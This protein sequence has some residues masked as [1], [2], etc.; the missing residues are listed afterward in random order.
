MPLVDLPHPSHHRS[1]IE[2]DLDAIRENVRRFRE[3]AGEEGGVMPAVKADA[4]GHGAVAVTREALAAGAA[5]VAVA[6][7][8]EGEELRAAG[9]DAPVL[10]LGASLPEEV[11]RAVG[12]GLGLGI[13]DLEIARL[14]SLE[15]M[16][17]GRRAVLHLKVDTG[18]GRLGILPE[19]AVR[20]AREIAGLP[21][22]V[23][24]G[25]YMHF[26]DATDEAYS[27]EQ[28]RRF[29]SATEA[30][31][32]SGVRPPLLHAANSAGAILYGDAR[33]DLIRPGAGVYG[34]HNPG[35]L[36][37][38]FPLEPALSWRCAI[39]QI[40]DYPPGSHLGYN[41]TFTTRRPTRVAV[42]PVG[43]ADGYL[44][45]FSNR[46]DV[47]VAGRRAPVV[48]LISMDYAMADVTEI[49]DIHKGSVVTLLGRDGAEAVT[50]EE[51][52]GH[53]GTVPYFITTGLGRRP[54]RLYVR[55]GAGNQP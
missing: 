14:A 7:C 25:V 52:A 1:W 43:Y 21:N 33:F 20:A 53:A 32:A 50:A 34:Y 5:R 44:R 48:G 30:L 16:R 15:A 55:A 42:L 8:E 47:L 36:R 26:A 4:Y 29:R 39:V 54:G 35:W 46:A 37:G 18:M 22:V 6:T 41:R 31:V 12:H 11:P 38:R 51:L 17:Q 49:P 19:N 9:I 23:L 40:K 45:G 10:I 28:L 13:H 3:L 24:E 2:V 27:R